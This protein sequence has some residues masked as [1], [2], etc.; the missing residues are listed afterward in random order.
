MRASRFLVLA[1]AL[2]AVGCRGGESTI[3]VGQPVTPAATTPKTGSAPS[4]PTPPASPSTAP[5][6]LYRKLLSAPVP[7]DIDDSTY[8]GRSVEAAGLDPKLR[9]HFHTVG[10]AVVEMSSPVNVDAAFTWF[11]VY[12]T[13]RLARARFELKR[14]EQGAVP[15]LDIRQPAVLVN[16]PFRATDVSGNPTT[17]GTSEVYILSGNVIVIGQTSRSDTTRRGDV[18]GAILLSKWGVRHLAKIRGGS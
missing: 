10:S 8:T 18:G 11:V 3:T 14:A 2:V 9:K 4:T 15:L 6:E 12:P 5:Q 1:G 16:F 17:Y 13:A 7:K